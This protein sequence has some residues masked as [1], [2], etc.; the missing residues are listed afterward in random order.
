MAFLRRLCQICLE[1][2]QQIFSSFGLAT[3]TF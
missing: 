1:L 2:N 3:V